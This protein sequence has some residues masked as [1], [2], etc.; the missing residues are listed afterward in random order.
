M[1]P[2]RRVIHKFVISR[3]KPCDLRDLC[4]TF[5]AEVAHHN[6]AGNNE[7]DGSARPTRPFLSLTRARMCARMR[8]RVRVRENPEKG[9]VG[10]GTTRKP[11]IVQNFRRAT[12]NFKVARGRVGRA[13]GNG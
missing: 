9:R 6:S 1:N 3:I 4:A 5:C 7:I 8:M 11:Q 13:W 12:F 10:R 2:A